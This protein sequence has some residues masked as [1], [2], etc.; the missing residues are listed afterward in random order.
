MEGVPGIRKQGDALSID[1]CV[2]RAWPGFTVAFRY[3]G[4][5]YD[6]VVN[7]PQGVSHGVSCVVVDGLRLVDGKSAVKLLDDGK[8]HRVT[9]TL[10]KP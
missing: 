4:T 3:G 7:N 5:R 9:V 6:I 2:P 1:P 10:G 8:L